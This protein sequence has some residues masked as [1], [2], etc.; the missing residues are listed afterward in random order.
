MN[1]F[2][3][4]IKDKLTKI[5]YLFLAFIV[6]VALFFTFAIPP[7]Q[8][9]D[10]VTHYH[11]SVNIASGNFFCNQKKI[12]LTNLW[13]YYLPEQL[14]Y[15]KLLG[16]W[17]ESFSVSNFKNTVDSFNKDMGEVECINLPSFGY[18]FTS[19]A[20]SFTNFFMNPVSSI[21]GFYLARLLNLFFFII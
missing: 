21:I 5:D 12:N 15:K 17:E 2:W 16:H 7:M 11:K 8:K 18:I 13:V 1:N 10:E 4:T 20:I 9:P 14:N 6:F 19:F 3:Q